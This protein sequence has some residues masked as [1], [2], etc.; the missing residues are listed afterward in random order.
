[1]AVK[2]SKKV[3]TGAGKPKGGVH[4]LGAKSR[5]ALIMCVDYRFWPST[6][7]HIK[8]TYNPAMM[9]LETT[10]GGPEKLAENSAGTHVALNELAISELFHQLEEVFLVMHQDCEVYDGGSLS[11]DSPEA[12]EAQ[13]RKDMATATEKI[14]TKFPGL[15]IIKLYA[16]FEGDDVKFKQI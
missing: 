14:K 13:V 8:Q 15:K 9:D 4:K 3:V 1:M 2:N 6:I 11:F 7:K 12:E 10:L 16:Y 5:A